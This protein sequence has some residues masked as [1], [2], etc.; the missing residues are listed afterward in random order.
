MGPMHRAV[1]TWAEGKRFGA[2]H[3][4]RVTG[5]PALAKVLRAL[6]AAA[7]QHAERV[8]ASA[9]KRRAAA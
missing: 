9:T 3:R 2:R 1:T 5:A 7:L 6:A 8:R 4:K